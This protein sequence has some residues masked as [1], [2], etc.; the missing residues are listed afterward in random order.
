[1]SEDKKNNYKLCYENLCLEFAKHDPTEMAIQSGALYDADKKQFTLT[2]LNREYLISY[3]AGSIQL[4]EPHEES[5][6]LDDEKCGLKIL[7]ISYLHRCTKTPLVKKWVPF[8]EL[9]GVGHTYDHFARQG[10]SKLVGFFGNK[11]ELF[12]KAV[13]KIGGKKYP[14]GDIG[15]E[16]NVLPNL[17]I[18]LILWLGDEEFDA[19]AAVLYDPSA[20]QQL[21]VE[22]LAVVGSL[23]ADELIWIANKL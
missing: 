14:S 5:P 20:V 18:V 19:T 16:I 11:G 6:L 4:K 9:K 12:S 1:M 8:R 22:D 15:F 10:I 3:P 23:V 7:L 2:Y 13:S 21:H 17:P